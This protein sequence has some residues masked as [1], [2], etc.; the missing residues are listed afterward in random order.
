MFAKRP[1]G[2]PGVTA[3]VS[4]PTAFNAEATVS[5]ITTSNAP[6]S[7]TTYR[8]SGCSRLAQIAPVGIGVRIAQNSARAA[9]ALP[10][11]YTARARMGLL[12]SARAH[13][14]T[15]AV[16]GSGPLLVA[17]TVRLGIRVSNALLLAQKTWR[18]LCALAM[19]RAAKG[20]AGRE[21]VCART[22]PRRGRGEVR[23][24]RHVFLANM[25]RPAPRSAPAH[26]TATATVLA[27]TGSS[28]TEHASAPPI[29]TATTVHVRVRAQGAF[30]A[31]VMVCA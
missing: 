16:K 11:P 8:A 6:V 23:V 13:A 4:R 28:A 2:A 21:R 9:R 5:A 29:I 31:P 19:E 7:Q 10:A 20:I 1:G 30:F 17:T 3:R 15:I 26:R 18:A 12:A 24:A 22:P 25:D 27:T 14:S